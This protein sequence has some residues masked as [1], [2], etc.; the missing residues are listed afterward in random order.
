MQIHDGVRSRRFWV[1]IACFVTFTGL[2]WFG[3]I[4]AGV[5]SNLMIFFIGGFL[6]SNWAEKR[7]VLK[8]ANKSTD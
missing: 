6:A 3:K 7:D 2:L 5:Y 8:H 1:T 4:N